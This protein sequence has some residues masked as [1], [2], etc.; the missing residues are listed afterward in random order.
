[1]KAVMS[2]KVLSPLGEDEYVRVKLGQVGDL[3]IATPLSRE[4]A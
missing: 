2:R 1:M 3:M 4:A